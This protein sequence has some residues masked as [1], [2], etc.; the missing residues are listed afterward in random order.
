MISNK[1]S[2]QSKQG[3]SHPQLGRCRSK[4]GRS[5]SGA[6]FSTSCSLILLVASSSS[7]S[8]AFISSN[9][10]HV[11]TLTITNSQL[12]SSSNV[13]SEVFQNAIG[14]LDRR[15]DSKEDNME[16]QRR[17]AI[18]D[19]NSNNRI[20]FVSPLLDDGYPPAVLEYERINDDIRNNNQRQRQKPML[21]YL[22]G[23]DGTI[24]APFLQFP[25]LGQEFDVRAM[26]IEMDD[27]SSFE[28]LKEAVT[29]YLLRECR[30]SDDQANGGLGEVY[31][32]GESFGGILATEVALEL[33]RQTYE[34]Y[35]DLRGLILVNPATSYLR[36]S[37]YE[38]GPPIATARPL[39]PALS[40]IQYIFSLVTQLV[41]LFLDQGRAI[42]QLLVI[43]S[44]KGLPSVVNDDQREAYMGR[45]AFDLANRLKF[46]PKDTLKWRLSEWL[47]W[48][49]GVFEDRL[50]MLQS[51]RDSTN[52][53]PGDAETY[54]LLKVSQELRTLIVVGELDLTLPSLEEADRLTSEV[55]R[56]AYVHVVPGAGHASTCGGSLDLIQLIRQV[57]PETNM[58]GNIEN[59]YDGNNGE[60]M[61]ELHG[62]E[63]RYDGASI[64]L[65]P[66]LYWS[67][68]YY[69]KWRRD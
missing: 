3:A 39:L 62:L 42:Q 33:N 48:G 32:M 11:N 24:L 66:L 30:G 27:R 59:K 47:E 67:K 23:F 31:L 58:Y 6:P 68:D 63:P 69:R 13:W 55:F 46:M 19:E 43:L 35:V 34:N 21:L 54:A 12:A 37:L 40:D 57:F 2:I 25:A 10:R 53:A 49:N 36:S 41:P 26:K 5:K 1:S 4:R 65:N 56:N 44:S 8:S 22:P 38:L 52:D 7:S 60:P 9:R 17:N 51:A 18:N 14:I 28:E 29:D 64:G 15:L 50:Q 16:K 45:V 20:Q 61:E